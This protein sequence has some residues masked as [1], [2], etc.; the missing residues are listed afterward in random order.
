METKK[1]NDITPV[2]PSNSRKILCG[3]GV[4]TVE[5]LGAFIVSALSAQVQQLGG[6]VGANENNITSLQTASGGHSSA[7]EDLQTAVG[8]LDSAVRNITS[9]GLLFNALAFR[10]YDTEHA[11]VADEYGYLTVKKTST[12]KLTLSIMTQAEYEEAFGEEDDEQ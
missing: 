5:A 1:I 11:A 12:G 9:A 6:R 3:D 4:L 7:I 8:N 2:S 10:V